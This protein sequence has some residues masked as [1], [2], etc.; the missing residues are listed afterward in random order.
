MLKNRARLQPPCV[1]PSTA[2]ILIKVVTSMFL[3]TR[4]LALWKGTVLGQHWAFLSISSPG[5]NM[6]S[7]MSPSD[8]GWAKAQNLD[9]CLKEETLFTLFFHDAPFFPACGDR[10]VGRSN[11]NSREKSSGC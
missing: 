6:M 4:W 3:D 10:L 8:E 2:L 7:G 1:S 9:P 11:D 5:M